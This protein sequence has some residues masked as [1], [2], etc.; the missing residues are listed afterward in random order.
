MPVNRVGTPTQVMGYDQVKSIKNGAAA[1]RA[2]GAAGRGDPGRENLLN[3]RMSQQELR[4]QA[5]AEFYKK[6]AE[7]LQAPQGYNIGKGQQ[8][9]PPAVAPPAQQ[10]MGDGGGGFG[11]GALFDWISKAFGQ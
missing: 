2:G 5:L 1:R 11:V 9:A 6:R 10:G 4:D 8:G 7:S 3:R